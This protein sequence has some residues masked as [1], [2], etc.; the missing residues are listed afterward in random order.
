MEPRTCCALGA[1]RTRAVRCDLLERD[2]AEMQVGGDGVVT[3][4]VAPFEIVTLRLELS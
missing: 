4:D 2:E 3:I 1:H